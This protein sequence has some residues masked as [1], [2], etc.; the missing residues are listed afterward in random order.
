M[1]FNPT[2]KSNSLIADIDFL[3]FGDSTTFNTDYSLI[4]RT[5]NINISLD[6][7]VAELHKADP[8]YQWDDSTNTDFPI[9]TIAVT[10]GLD[11]YDLIDSTAIIH[12]V[13][14][15]L[16]SGKWKRLTPRLRSEFSDS[17][18]AS[19]GSP[20][21]FYKLGQA[22]FPVPVPNYGIAAGVELTFQRGANHFTTSST[23][24]EPG[25]NPQFHQFLSVNASLRYA[26]A[27]GLREKI[28]ALSSM[29]KEIQ[30]A[31]LTH[32]E[33]RS[34]DDRTRMRLKRRPGNY[35]L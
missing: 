32:Y 19:T 26:V 3:L 13:R 5:R 20:D 34:P 11:H 23:D 16:P 1:K 31:V 4:D 14:F 8:N 10:E 7:I 28:N 18:L 15:R 29:K 17:E 24:T 2:D 22:I 33:R 12:G 21:S 25:F 9:A 35:G 6:E 30:T 27:N